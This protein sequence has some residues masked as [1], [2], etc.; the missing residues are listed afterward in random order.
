[1]FSCAEMR[2]QEVWRSTNKALGC[3][4]HWRW[5]KTSA[6]NVFF[7]NEISFVFNNIIMGSH[8][9]LP[10]L[11]FS[12]AMTYF[13]FYTY[14]YI[15][16]TY[17]STYTSTYTLHILQ[18]QLNFYTELIPLSWHYYIGHSVFEI[19]KK[20]K[21]IASISHDRKHPRIDSFAI[22]LLSESHWSKY[23]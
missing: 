18:Q 17:T 14:F 22:I 21:R 2:S 11:S 23:I 13:D 12:F 8:L 10:I 16:F 6:T 15:Y 4:L 20:R 9:F 3:L 5:K 19:I 7:C 1:M